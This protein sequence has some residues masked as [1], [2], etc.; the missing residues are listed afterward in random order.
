MGLR[1]ATKVYPDVS[2]DIFTDIESGVT[3]SKLFSIKK[4]E[5]QVR[6]NLTVMCLK[7]D[8][9]C[10]DCTAA[11]GEPDKILCCLRT[12]DNV[13]LF[14]DY[15]K[16]KAYKTAYSFRIKGKFALTKIGD[17]TYIYRITSKETLS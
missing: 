3:V 6:D 15:V 5:H 2:V 7:Y 4:N 10:V 17:K 14:V 16:N 12:F 9:R 1:T 11:W 8:L 13:D